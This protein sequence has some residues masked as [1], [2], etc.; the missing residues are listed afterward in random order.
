MRSLEAFLRVLFHVKFLVELCDLCGA[1]CPPG[2]DGTAGTKKFYLHT[3][4]ITWLQATTGCFAGTVLATW[5]T[6]AEFNKV[7]SKAQFLIECDAV[8]MTQLYDALDLFRQ[9]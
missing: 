8:F 9:V 5:E 2:E 3:S 1:A 6:Q 4:E 7:K